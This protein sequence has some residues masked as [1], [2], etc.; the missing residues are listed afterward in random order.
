M[1]LDYLKSN[2]IVFAALIAALT[3][4]VV[5]VIM[6]FFN[7][8]SSRRLE[9]IKTELQEQ[10]EGTRAQLSDLNSTRN[11]RRD[12]E[13]EARKRLYSEIEPLLFQLFEA[14]EQAYFRVRSLSRSSQN[15]SLNN[16]EGNWLHDDSSYYLH[17]TIYYLIL[18]SVIFRLIQRR[19]T[20]V[21]LDLDESIAV[22]YF[23]LKIYY[24]VI[25]DHFVVAKMEPECPYDPDHE[26][27]TSLS[28]TNP[29]TYRRQGLVVGDLDVLLDHLLVDDDNATRAMTFGEFSKLLGSDDPSGTI[30]EI[31]DLFRDFSPQTRPVLARLLLILACLSDLIL[32]FYELEDRSELSDIVRQFVNSNEFGISFS[33]VKGV[34]L[35]KAERELIEAYVIERLS[36]IPERNR[37]KF[38]LTV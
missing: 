4:A 20:F 9:R 21:D 14:T 30:S 13:Y 15:G 11:A 23:L 36:W 37:Q 7:V 2:P 25:T 17:S 3:S 1:I 18:P 10:I 32:H 24:Y 6:Q 29:A 38:S 22:K 28:E 33:W 8:F 27:W 34:E 16:D 12:Y 35:D 31:K 19:M 26:N 5:S